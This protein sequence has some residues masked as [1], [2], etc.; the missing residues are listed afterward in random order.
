[1][2]RQSAPVNYFSTPVYTWFLCVHDLVTNEIMTY[3]ACWHYSSI[4]FNNDSNDQKSQ[5]CQSF[6][7]FARHLGTGAQFHNVSSTLIFKDSSNQTAR[8]FFI[9]FDGTR[10]QN[11][12]KHLK[13]LLQ[14]ARRVHIMINDMVLSRK[15][16]KYH[17][18][19][20]NITICHQRS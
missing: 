11:A 8:K 9:A 10:Q 3:L 14:Q 5:P 6:Q 19:S 4:S 17:Q 1:M 12:Q 20:P 7:L 18:R 13:P 15:I 16:I 2:G